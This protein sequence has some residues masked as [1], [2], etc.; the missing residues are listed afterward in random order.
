MERI[1]V[2]S[3]NIKS[4]GHEN[5]VLEIEFHNGGIYQYQGVSKVL[6]EELMHSESVGGYFHTYIKGKFP[7]KKIER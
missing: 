2:K 1:E 7:Y 4:I 3:S 5:D 6:F